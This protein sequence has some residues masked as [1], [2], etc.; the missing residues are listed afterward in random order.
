VAALNCSGG[1]RGSDAPADAPHPRALDPRPRNDQCIDAPGGVIVTP[2]LVPEG[3]DESWTATWSD[4]GWL[5]RRQTWILGPGPCCPPAD[6]L[7]A[8]TVRQ[9]SCARA[10]AP[11]QTPPGARPA[12]G[13]RRHVPQPRLST[14]RG[15][16]DVQQRT[17]L[18]A[19]LN[20]GVPAPRP[21]PGATGPLEHGSPHR[22]SSVR[23]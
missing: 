9:L 16:I 10:C 2:S 1:Y 6:A 17:H 12:G 13:T 11:P 23:A 3:S 18:T 21:D 5:S 8:A 22:T 7:H 4:G 15:R 20:L 14:D 19:R